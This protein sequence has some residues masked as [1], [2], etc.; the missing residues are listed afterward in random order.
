[1]I[2]IFISYSYDNTE[3]EDWVSRLACDLEQYKEINVVYDKF[4]LTKFTDKNYF[5]EKGVFN[6]HYVII[7]TSENF[8]NKANN[9]DGGVGIETF[10][11]SSRHWEEMIDEKQS[12]II[13]VLR[14]NK[15]KLLPNYLKGKIY[16]NFNDDNNYG[17][18]LEELIKIISNQDLLKRP[19]KTKTIFEQKRVFNFSQTEQLISVNHTRR[20]KILETTDFSEK[21]RIKY[22]YWEV[23]NPSPQYFLILFDNI[24]IKET[25]EHFISKQTYLPTELT[26]LRSKSSGYTEKIFQDHKIKIKINEFSFSDYIWDYCIDD[27]AKTAEELYEDS[28]FIDQKVY[29]LEGNQRTILEN[30]LEYIENKFLIDDN[31]KPIQLL[32]APGGMGKST[33]CHVVVNN[34]NKTI[35]R[36]A[37][38][39]QSESIKRYGDQD[40]LAN[41]AIES[42]YDL[43]EIYSKIKKTKGGIGSF[44]NKRIFDLSLLCGNIV[45]VIDGLDEIIGFFQEKFNVNAFFKS[46]VCLNQE[47]GR[48]N[49]IIT[50]REYY[51][52]NN[53]LFEK[54]KNDIDEIYLLGFDDHTLEDY[55]K[56][57]FYTHPKKEE[58]KSLAKKYISS[59]L[60]S[61]EG[62]MVPFFVDVISQVVQDEVDSN[63]SKFTYDFPKRD[64]KSN[65]SLIDYLIYALLNRE[66][67]RQAYDINLSDFVNMFKDIASEYNGFVEHEQL[68]EIIELHFNTKS[69]EILEKMLLNPLL[70]S[71]NGGVKFK[72]DFLT[73]Y[74]ISLY[75]IEGICSKSESET[76]LT[77]LSRLYDGKNQ[78]IKDLI[79]YFESKNDDLFLN[80]RQ[81]LDTLLS[82]HKKTSAKNKLTIYEKAISALMHLTQTAKGLTVEKSTRTELIKY[83]YNSDDKIEYLF[84]YGSFY[85]F[86]LT[87]TEVWHS[88]FHNYSNIF[89]CKFDNTKFFYTDFNDI[90]LTKDAFKIKNASFDSTCNLGNLT[91]LVNSDDPDSINIDILEK[92]LKKFF[93]SF[94]VRG[95]YKNKL[96][97][98]VSFSKKVPMINKSFLSHLCTEG[99]VEY[100]PV[101]KRYGISTSYQRRVHNYIINNLCD[102]KI[103]KIIKQIISLS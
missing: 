9:R 47:L 82:L 71:S 102:V 66:K 86:D 94:Y 42:I 25:V 16:I 78:I 22:E 44:M 6:S 34:I 38:F 74:F 100:D 21:K 43:Y 15:N 8:T 76:F 83:I 73:N 27:E 57:R 37:I 72:Y 91:D 70:I 4:D 55:F 31:F 46:L 61:D 103:N 2:D 7:V 63:E 79:N 1:M 59:S 68:N 69:D 14:S 80:A 98:Q 85:S 35:N 32:I 17:T 60:L 13:T 50:S 10:M 56:K 5:M 23:K 53:Q 99:V 18:K 33:L 54:Y 75:L 89:K 48:S 93:R 64:Y 45:V 40:F 11:T 88:K 41:F 77:H 39:I 24:N 95:I 28:Y 3:H 92:E 51:W 29:R 36:R 87:N 26:I 65:D 62:T 19:S 81:I 67:V 90:I 52:R 84:I 101:G 96:L 12:N 49:I 58:C 30:S 20:K 97:E